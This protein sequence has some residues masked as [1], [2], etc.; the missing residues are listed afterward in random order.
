MFPICQPATNCA[1]WP[2]TSFGTLSKRRPHTWYR[3]TSQLSYL[4]H[5]FAPHHLALRHRLPGEKPGLRQKAKQ[6]ASSLAFGKEVPVQTHGQDKYNRTLAD[7]RL[8]DGANVNHELV[9]EGWFCS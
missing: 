3:Q 1:L 2:I 5:L 6:A 8:P 4:R 9:K 7:V